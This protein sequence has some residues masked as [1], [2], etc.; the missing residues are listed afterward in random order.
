MQL[1]SH[2]GRTGA[3]AG[4][5]PTADHPLVIAVGND[6]QFAALAKGLGVPELFS[7]PR[8][9][10]N[11]DRVAHVD[12][13]YDAIAARLSQQPAATWFDIL[14]PLGI[15]CGPVNTMAEAFEFEEALGLDARVDVGE[16]D[17]AVTVV[18]NPIELSAT[19]AQYPPGTR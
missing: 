12:A 6:R 17:Q 19:P 4:V 10:T 18:A 14:S 15:P 5:P 7:D 11:P 8:F 16:G 2:G 3:Q 9:R 1:A 13:L